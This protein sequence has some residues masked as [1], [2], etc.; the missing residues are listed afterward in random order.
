[1][2]GHER[3]HLTGADPDDGPEIGE[4]ATAVR[5]EQLEQPHVGRIEIRT[6]CHQYLFIRLMSLARQASLGYTSSTRILDVDRPRMCGGHSSPR[7]PRSGGDPVI[8][9]LIGLLA[10]FSLL[11]ILFGTEDH[12]QDTFDPRSDMF[13]R[14]SFGIR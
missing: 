3:P 7:R 9:G 6:M 14:L 4:R 11:S 2:V 12:R 8:A 10:L 5:L 1:M 13:L